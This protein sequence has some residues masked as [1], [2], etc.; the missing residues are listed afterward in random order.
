VLG[1]TEWGRESHYVGTKNLDDQHHSQCIPE[2][3]PGNSRKYQT[4]EPQLACGDCPSVKTHCYTRSGG[5]IQAQGSA[6]VPKA[7]YD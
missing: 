1:P 2:T 7:V 4:L 5:L 3:C 6:G